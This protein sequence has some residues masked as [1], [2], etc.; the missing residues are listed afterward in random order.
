MI[1]MLMTWNYTKDRFGEWM[2]YWTR[3]TV[4]GVETMCHPKT[5]A[6]CIKWCKILN[7]EH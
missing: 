6:D 2:V 7:G 3:G 4:K 5:E 1:Q